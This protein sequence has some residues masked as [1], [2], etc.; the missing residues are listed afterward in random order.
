MI[1]RSLSRATAVVALLLTLAAA[2]AAVRRRQPALPLDG[3]G[4]GRA[5]RA[6]RDR[7]QAGLG[8]PGSGVVFRHEDL[9]GEFALDG[10]GNFAMPLVGEIQAYGLTTREL[11]QRIAS[12]LQDGYLIEP[13]V[14][15]E[16]LNYRPFYILGEVKAPGSYQFVNGMTVL[17]AVALAGGF[18]YRA[19]QN[20]FL[21][22]RG[23]SNTAGSRVGI[24]TPILPGDI[25]TVQERF[26]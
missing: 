22:Q 18:T 5:G 1:G 11:E 8:R 7:L 10:A 16:V 6:G 19:K 25:V 9:S 15:V 21:L 20:D 13:Q 17:N 3:G 23:G 4:P 26:F 2:A 12:K 24:E 14:S